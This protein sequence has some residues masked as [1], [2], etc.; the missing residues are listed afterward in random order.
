M[1]LQLPEVVSNLLTAQKNYDSDAYADCFSETALVIDE[2]KE[3][4]FHILF[5]QII[6]VRSRSTIAT[7]IFSFNLVSIDYIILIFVKL[8][9]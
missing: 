7:L 8:L 1:D 4:I 3:P 5:L 9:T 2:E 6:L